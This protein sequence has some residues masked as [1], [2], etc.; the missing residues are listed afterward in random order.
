MLFEAFNKI[1]SPSFAICFN[2]LVACKF[3]LYVYTFSFC[4]PDS[5]AASAI[6]CASFPTVINMSILFFSTSFPT[7]SCNSCEKSPTS[8][9]SPNTAIFLPPSNDAKYSKLGFIDSKLA[10]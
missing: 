1:L 2:F 5:K 7:F 3:V 4:I 8:F 10:L 6:Y 9:I